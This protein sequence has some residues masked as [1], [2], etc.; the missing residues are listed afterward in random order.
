MPRLRLL[1]VAA[2]LIGAGCSGS[3][4]GY[5]SNPPPPPPPGPPPPPPSGGRSTTI[6]VADF[7]F[8]PTPDTVSAGTLTFQWAPTATT[9]NVTWQT[10][11]A[12]PASSGNKAGGDS[13]QV[14][15]QTAGTYTYHCT[16]HS[17][18]TGVVVVQ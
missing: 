4:T 11:P 7:S 5:G 10:G 9:H 3:S 12:S 8:S 14:N 18:M 13:H 16:L 1:A 2:L 17:Q 15:L 6:T